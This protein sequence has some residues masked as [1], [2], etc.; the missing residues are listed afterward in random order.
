[1]ALL[2]AMLMDDDSK[3][4]HPDGIEQEHLA[5]AR[6]ASTMCEA[7]LL[8]SSCGCSKA[9][10]SPGQMQPCS[11]ARQLHPAAAETGMAELEAPT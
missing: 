4:K 3:G 8:V 5:H 2:Q 6:D 9:G 7:Q 10:G 11:S 1:M